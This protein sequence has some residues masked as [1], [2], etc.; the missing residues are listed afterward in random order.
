[1]TKLNTWELKINWMYAGKDS[2]L[3]DVLVGLDNYGNRYRKVGKVCYCESVLKKL[4]SGMTPE[5]A[6]LNA[7]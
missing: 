6:V 5:E 3:Q 7:L 2:C 1:M 4:G